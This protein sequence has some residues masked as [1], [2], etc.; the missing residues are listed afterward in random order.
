MKYATPLLSVVL[1]VVVAALSFQLVQRQLSEAAFAFTV[2]PEVL[3]QLEQ[4]LA[5]QRELA[6]L[7]PDQTAAYRQRF[8]ELE[9]TVH[10]LQILTHSRD[11]MVK[12]YE[13]ILLVVF[14]VIVLVVAGVSVVRHMRL[15]PRLTRLQ[16]ALT[17]LAAGR[18]DLEVEVQGRDVV[19][20]IAAMVEETSRV[21][22]GDRRRLAALKNLSSWQEAAR[23]HAH[24]MRTP[25]G[26]RLEIER[27]RDLVRG[28]LEADI[29]ALDNAASGALDEL[30]RLGVFTRQFTSFARLPR[31]QLVHIDLVRVLTEFV[32]TY[33]TA[34]TNLRLE[35]DA[36]PG[37]EVAIDH[38]MI[39]R[40]LVNL[41]DNASRAIG[42]SSGEVTL[43]VSATRDDVVL[44]VIDDGPGVDESVRER[45]FD[46]YTTTRTIGE[47]MG[48]GLAISKKILLE[49]GG[50]LGLHESSSD[51]TT[52]RLTLPHPGER[53]AEP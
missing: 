51:G 31:P 48:L 25:T 27:I 8:D 53:N 36:V 26:A 42:D 12:R 28:G 21:M 4:S 39:R 34:W 7:E 19:G 33:E 1:L 13:T 40:V 16:K 23:R 10:R 9:Q 49:Q 11:R 17:G 22:A 32:D 5:D 18:T 52:F 3:A 35:L 20:R 44:D 50:D 38:E 47:G 29:E 41:C 37:Y 2:N 15:Q 6:R 45:V 14:A 24:E 30:D 46:P 43:R